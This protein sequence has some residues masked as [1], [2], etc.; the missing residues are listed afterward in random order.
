MAKKKLISKS[1]DAKKALQLAIHNVLFGR[2]A[3]KKRGVPRTT[4]QGRL[5]GRQ[6][7]HTAHEYQQALLDAEEAEIVRWNCMGDPAAYLGKHWIE[8]FLNRHPELKV[9]TSKR[10]DE[11]RVM[12]KNPANVMEFYVI[13]SNVL[14][15][16]KIDHTCIFNLDEK[17]FPMGLTGK[18]KVVILTWDHRDG[19]AGDGTRK[20]V[21]T[22]ECICAN[23]TVLP[24]MIIMKGKNVQK[25]WQEGSPLDPSTQWACSPN[26]WTDN[27]LGVEYIKAFDEWTAEKASNGQWHC[28]ILDGHGSHLTYEFLQYTWDA[29]IIV[30]GLPSH[31]TDFLQPLDRVVFRALQ[32]YYSQA[33]GKWMQQMLHVTKSSFSFVLHTARVQAYTE[34]N[35]LSAFEATG[36]WP[37]EPY[38]SLLMQE[39]LKMACNQSAGSSSKAHALS[40]RQVDI[41]DNARALIKDNTA[42]AKALQQALAEVLSLAES[43]KARA[44]L[45]EEDLQQLWGSV[46]E[47]TKKKP[48]NGQVGQAQVYTQ[49]EID[50]I[51]KKDEESCAQCK[52]SQGQGWGR[53]GKGWGAS[54]KVTGGRKAPKGD[55]DTNSEAQITPESEYQPESEGL[56]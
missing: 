19:Y 56:A 24:P 13:L 47:K 9:T 43:S 49:K 4:L 37:L 53:G 41:M 22:I 8:Q 6:D 28:L 30:I 26:G 35:I 18:E 17:G 5:D 1:V 14:Q 21:T 23:G 15:G 11:K 25:A 32:W 39:F 46:E 7:Q 16:Y 36:I 31:T 27:E 44:T 29:H 55:I 38:W 34:E 10:I 52:A 54:R 2:Q 42:S 33:V 50:K 3:A 20:L 12:A 45:V 48:Q 51:C 40:D